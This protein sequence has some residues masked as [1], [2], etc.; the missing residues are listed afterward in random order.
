MEALEFFKARKRM[1]EATKCDSCKLYHVQQGGCCISPC[2]ENIDAFEKA[3]AIVGQW[4]K[5][6][7]RRK[8]RRSGELSQLLEAWNR[9]T[10]N[11]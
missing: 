9:R 6:G 2:H 5:L 8:G 11:D 1:C 10:D 4:N 3:I 7:P